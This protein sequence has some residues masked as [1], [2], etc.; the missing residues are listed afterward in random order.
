MRLLSSA[1]NM[2][3]AASDTLASGEETSETVRGRGRGIKDRGKWANKTEFRL[4]MAGAVIGLGNIW[5]FPYI[6]YLS[7]GGAFLIL[8]LLFLFFCGMPMF[9]LET[10]LGQYTS[11]GPFT[12][13]RKMCPM[14]QGIGIASQVIVLCQSVTNVVILAWTLFYL[15][16]S[17]T[18]PLPWSSCKNVWN[19]ADCRNQSTSADWSYF[20]NAS[21]PYPAYERSAEEEF[22]RFHV[23]GDM[24]GGEFSADLGGVRWDLA[25]CLLLAWA[26]CY[27]CVWKGVKYIGKVVY[28]TVAFPF[29]LL[30]IFFIR[31]VT[32]PGAWQGITYFVYPQFNALRSGYVW[33]YALFEASYTHGVCHGVLITLGSY[34][35]Y[36]HDCYKDCL[37]LCAL[38]TV[39]SIFAGVV[40]FALLGFG[41]ESA[42]VPFDEI[43][44]FGP[45]LPF[46]SMSRVFSALPVPQLWSVLFFLMVFFF[47]LDNQFLMTESLVT[48]ISDVFPDALRKYH[49]VLVLVTVAVCFLLGLPLVTREGFTMIAIFGVSA[50]SLMFIMCF[51]TIA[52]GWIYGADRFYDNIED[53][54]GYRP[55]PV[56]KYCWLFVAPLCGVAFIIY[57]LATPWVDAGFWTPRIQAFLLL[58]PM[59]C[60]PLFVV[61]AISKNED[62]I[63]TPAS[64]LK[65]AR[66]S[67]P[68]LSLCKNA[69]FKGRKSDG[70]R[71]SGEKPAAE[72]TTAV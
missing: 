70:V 7:G 45:G 10:A 46:T 38:T 56:I 69:I 35:T 14:F 20:D 48:T 59:L 16:N 17:F 37:V 65:Q 71:A 34:N 11:E 44:S 39:I 47:V 57:S 21:D 55:F 43:L 5:R 52:I 64:D 31:G 58:L 62:D 13:W 30:F 1:D 33:H 25:L 15:Y 12:A 51:E 32:L 9:F 36:K 53:M 68:R 27:F 42:G 60:I 24:D 18:N 49:E 40:I 41:A 63:T 6:V 66:P 28:F 2:E 67:K 22:W 4:A 19:T 8:Y 72:S 23:A 26:A 29:L 54:I 3:P 61:V 50:I